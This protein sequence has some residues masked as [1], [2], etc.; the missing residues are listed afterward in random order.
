M[1]TLIVARARDGAIGRDGDIP[2]HAPED[3]A[4]F[5]RETLGGALIMGRRTWQSLPVRPLKNRLNIV[6]TSGTA[7]GADHVARSLDAALE[8]ARDAG[9]TR[10]YGIGGA[11]I[12]EG[13]LGRADR[14]LITEVALDVPDADTRFPAFDETE[15]HEIQVLPLRADSPA[16]TLHEWM[17]RGV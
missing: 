1:L 2:W 8:I 13:L 12:Y 11:S 3:L 4:M 15:W 14:L 6:V 9:M 16:C 17:R 10:V 5:K 7:E